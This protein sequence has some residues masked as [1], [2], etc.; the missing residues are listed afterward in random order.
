MKGTINT[1]E[2]MKSLYIRLCSYL[3]EFS[4]FLI[5]SRFSDRIKEWIQSK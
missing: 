5:I 3:I 4:S 2:G 1:I